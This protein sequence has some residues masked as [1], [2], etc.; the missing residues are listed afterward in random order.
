[1]IR[2]NEVVRGVLWILLFTGAL[3]AQQP[4]VADPN[5]PVS[6]S[7]PNGHVM[8]VIPGGDP[9]TGVSWYDA[10]RYSNWLSER[11]R[12]AMKGVASRRILALIAELE[13]EGEL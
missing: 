9:Q 11:A 3:A 10:A 2:V 7:V 12:T 8:L 5:R 13:A 1:M 6:Y 4:P